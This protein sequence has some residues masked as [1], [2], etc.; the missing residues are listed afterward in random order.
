MSI[1]FATVLLFQN[2]SRIQNNKKQKVKESEPFTFVT[3]AL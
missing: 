3:N 2:S 1:N